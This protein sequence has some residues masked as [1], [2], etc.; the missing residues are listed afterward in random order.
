MAFAGFLRPRRL[1]DIALLTARRRQRRVVRRLRRLAVLELSDA[2][3]QRIVL[4]YQ[5]RDARRELAVLPQQLQHQRLHIVRK[6]IDL[7]WLH[8][9]LNQLAWK[10]STPYTRVTPPQEVSS[11]PLSA[12]CRAML[13]TVAVTDFQN[14]RK[15]PARSM[16]MT[17]IAP[18]WRT[19]KR[20]WHSN[21]GRLSHRS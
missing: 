13:R 19:P 14:V 12:I 17:T 18:N 16:A 15:G 9:N 4:R 11:Y 20:T 7:L 10:N 1:R 8:T 3:Q 6:P 2:G 5:L 21:A